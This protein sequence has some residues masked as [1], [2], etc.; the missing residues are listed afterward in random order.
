MIMRLLKYQ[1]VTRTIGHIKL[2]FR[3]A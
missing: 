1:V 2:P 3:M